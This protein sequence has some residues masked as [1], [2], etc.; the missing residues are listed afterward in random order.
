MM[1]QD[2]DYQVALKG[3]TDGIQYRGEVSVDLHMEVYRDN[4]AKLQIAEKPEIPSG[5]LSTADIAHLCQGWVQP[6]VCP[7]YFQY[8]MLVKEN[9]ELK[10]KTIKQKWIEKKKSLKFHQFLIYLIG[11]GLEIAGIKIKKW[12]RPEEDYLD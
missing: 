5:Y 8:D 3:F 6:A 12:G 10:Q 1:D 7:K 4:F 11:R 2:L 9:G